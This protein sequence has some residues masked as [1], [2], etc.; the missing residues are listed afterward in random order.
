MELQLDWEF[1]YAAGVALK[2]KAKKNLIWGPKAGDSIFKIVLLSK[3]RQC[4]RQF[5]HTTH[6]EF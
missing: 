3:A 4:I 2:K 5:I 6:M 1:P